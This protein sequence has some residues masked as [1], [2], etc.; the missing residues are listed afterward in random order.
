MT[1]KIKE[2][3]IHD[4]ASCYD[5]LFSDKENFRYFR[6]LGWSY[7]QFKK[8]LIK[9]INFA[10]GLFEE[11]TLNAFIIGN[12]I[13]IDDVLE[14]EILLIYVNKKTRNIGYATKL[15]KYIELTFDKK[16]S[17]IYLE[18]AE[19]NQK[20]IKLYTKYDYKKI[21]IRK[22]Y[23]KFGKIFTNAIVFQKII[24]KKKYD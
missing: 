8:Q 6:E 11:K 10:M 24:N 14:Y 20:A 18:V 12:L 17:K 16:F 9:D 19:N 3:T 23:Y 5:L 2:L 7:D 22:N 13:D 4:F 21:G 1:N 15:L